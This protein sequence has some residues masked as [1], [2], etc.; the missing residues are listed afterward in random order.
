MKDNICLEIQ[1]ISKT[2]GSADEKGRGET[3]A[4]QNLSFEVPEG[5]FFTIIGPS[6]CGKSTLL[7]II[8]GLMPPDEGKILSHGKEITK[9]GQD[10]GMVFQN[11]NLL[12]WRTVI[13]NVGFGL[14]LMK[15]PKKTWEEKAKFYIDLVGL[16]GFE[17]Y[18]PYELSGGMQQ[19]VGLA[20]A[21]AVDPEVLLMDEPFG[22]VDE[23]TREFL[24]VELL[25]IWD[26]EHKTIVFVTHSIE[27]AVFMSDT[28]V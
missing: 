16:K 18:Y 21:L 3:K 13:D 11:F 22:S 2:Y 27:E 8:D 4:L 24:Q 19:R 15:L 25:R 26:H 9:P 17:H 14:E 6:G 10:R 28:V 1:N 23:Q 12:P 5:R 7:R 20:R